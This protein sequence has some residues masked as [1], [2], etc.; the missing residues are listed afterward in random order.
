M[1][2]D[3]NFYTVLSLHQAGQLFTVEV[4]VNDNHPLF[5]GHFPSQPVVP[6]VVT[7]T[8]LREQL[9]VIVGRKVRFTTLKEC[10]FVSALVPRKGLRL[11]LEMTINAD[12]LRAVVYDGERVALKLSTHFYTYPLR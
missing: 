8:I 9:A 1:L 10:K 3:G 6:G 7:M 4:E 11:R 2:F 12:H 5:G